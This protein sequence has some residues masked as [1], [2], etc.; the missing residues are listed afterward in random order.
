MWDRWGKIALAVSILALLLLEWR[1]PEFRQGWSWKDPRFRHRE[2][3][4]GER[5]VGQPEVEDRHHLG[6]RAR[7][8]PGEVGGVPVTMRPLPLQRAQ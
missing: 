8:V 1:D 3:V 7:G 6:V 4:R 5:A 2:I